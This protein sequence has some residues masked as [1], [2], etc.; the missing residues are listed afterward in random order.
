MYMRTLGWLRWTRAMCKVNVHAHAGVDE[1]DA[2][3]VYGK[4]SSDAVQNNLLLFA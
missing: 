3:D 2:R 1:M 4:S